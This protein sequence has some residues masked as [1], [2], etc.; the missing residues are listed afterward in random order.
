ME[1]FF[2]PW[3]CLQKAGDCQ[4]IL[5]MFLHAYGKRLEA[6]VHQVTVKGGG[7]WTNSCKQS[8]K[9]KA[10]GTEHRGLDKAAVNGSGGLIQRNRQSNSEK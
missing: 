2:H 1:D 9:S 8:N 5:V 10:V 7:H 3:I 6:A 4:S